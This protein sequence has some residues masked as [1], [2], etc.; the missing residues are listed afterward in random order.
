VRRASCDPAD[1]VLVAHADNLPGSKIHLD[2]VLRRGDLTPDLWLCAS[3]IS[4]ILP[5]LL[6]EAT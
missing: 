1:T 4:V 2:Q 3:K 5:L 6:P